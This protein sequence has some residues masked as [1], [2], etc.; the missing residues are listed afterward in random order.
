MLP[1]D[2][3]GRVQ[4]D[5]SPLDGFLPPG[6]RFILARA[7]THDDHGYAPVHTAIGGNQRSEI[8][9]A[10]NRHHI[11]IRLLQSRPERTAKL[12]LVWIDICGFGKARKSVMP[13]RRGLC[14]ARV[15][16][17]G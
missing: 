17:F 10:I 11:W 14:V 4:T 3:C 12:G 8:I 13:R 16:A 1:A 6:A 9:P 2:E 15:I 5:D 7:L